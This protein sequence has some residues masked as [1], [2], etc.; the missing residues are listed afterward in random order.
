MAQNTIAKAYDILQD[1][2]GTN[3]QINYYKKLL[4]NKRLILDDFSSQYIVRNHDYEPIVVNKIVKISSELGDFL[5]DKFNL[6]MIPQQVYIDRVIGEMGGSYH[7]YIK[8]KVAGTTLLYLKKRGILDKLVDVDYKS[9]DIDFD[10]FDKQ[11]EHLGRKIREYQKD[12]IKFMVANKKCINADEQGTG[13]TSQAVLAALAGGYNHILVITTASLKTTWKKDIQLYVPEDEIQIVNG[14]KWEAGKRFTVLN[15]DIVQNFYEVPMV[16]VYETEE[17]R[18]SNGYVVETLQVPVMVKDKKSGK[19]VPKMQKSRKKS[20]IVESLNKSPLFLE[21]YDCVIIDEAQKLSNKG[22]IRYTAISDFLVKSAPKAIFLLTG[23]PLTN[24]PINLYN[25]LKLIDADVTHDYRYYMTRYCGGHEHTKRDGGKFWTFDGATNIPE[26]R[27]KIKDV[28]IRRLA[29]ET[30]EMVKKDIVRRYY[31]LTSEQHME[32]QK[33]WDEYINAQ[34]VEKHEETEQYRQLIEGMLV[35]QYLAKEMVQHTID[36]ADE[37]IEDGE[38]VVIITCFQEEMNMIKEH[39]GKSCV[40]YNGSMTAKQ[41]DKAQDAFM[42]DKNVKVFVGQIIA[43]GVGLSLPVSRKL[44]FNSYDW[45]AAN[46][47][48]AESR[49]HRLT[50]TQDVECI[51]M[52]FNDSISQEMFDKVLYKGYLMDSLVKSEQQKNQK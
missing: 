15:Y 3:N 47:R 11:T 18:D 13:K 32:Y 40:T 29:A 12:G 42:N 27:E 33:L 19:M 52:L 26:L 37:M 31:D 9:L 28:Y 35:R 20:D 51:Y 24:D 6:G 4:D 25:I 45:V 14:S 7:C 23:T 38:K 46:N 16:P 43:C 5:C 49:I 41:K 34:D 22:S 17:I 48:Q 44:I 8:T 1:Y 21:D 39:Y 50:Q 30:G 36:L 2:K 10:Y